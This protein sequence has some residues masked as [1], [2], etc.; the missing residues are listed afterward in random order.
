[1]TAV[2]WGRSRAR[3]RGRR[4]SGRTTRD[5]AGLPG[6]ADRGAGRPRRRAAG[7]VRPQRARDHRPAALRRGLA[8]QTGRCAGPSGLLRVGGHRRG[9]R[10]AA[11]GH[12]RPA[13]R[14][15]SAT[16]AAPL[17][18]RVFK[19]DRGPAGEKIAYVRM[20]A[21]T[22]GVRQPCPSRAAGQATARAATATSAGR[23]GGGPAEGGQGD[24]H[25]RR[26][27]RRL[28]PPP[29]AVGRRDRQAV[30]VWPPSA[31]ATRSD[32][33]RTGAGAAPLRAADDGDRRRAGPA[34]ATTGRCAARWPC[35]PS[36][37]R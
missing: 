21:G 24:G 4:G 14:P 32:G 28:G 30:G 33:R 36:R 6:D 27:G 26:L 19:I 3:A 20:F 2:R 5:D 10:R 22:A 31:S 23:T 29:A 25:Q 11:R 35:W 7:G 1:M 9:R 17:S 15:R 34:A 16:P 13:A 18:A 8:D 37:T 12:R